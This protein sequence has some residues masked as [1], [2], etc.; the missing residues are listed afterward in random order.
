MILSGC[1][2][3]AN[4]SDDVFAGGYGILDFKMPEMNVTIDTKTY[5]HCI[6]PVTLCACLKK[7]LSDSIKFI[8]NFIKCAIA[9]TCTCNFRI[10]SL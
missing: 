7:S 3:C 8:L 10:F 1:M 9:S 4:V 5:Q 6:K 2:Y